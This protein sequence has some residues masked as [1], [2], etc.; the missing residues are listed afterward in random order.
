MVSMSW[1]KLRSR[2][3][4]R[5]GQ[6]GLEPH[7]HERYERTEAYQHQ[8]F[9]FGRDDREDMDGL[10]LLAGL[11]CRLWGRLRLIWRQH[12]HGDSSK[13]RTGRSIVEVRTR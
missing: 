2:A 1:N 12:L 9:G 4:K 6:G 8:P 5:V 7:H 10:R 3:T 11:G 13:A